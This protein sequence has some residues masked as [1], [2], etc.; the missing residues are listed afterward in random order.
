MNILVTGGTGF[1]G[2]HTIVSLLNEGHHV[3]AFD[4]F[5]NSKETVVEAIE[6]ITGKSFVFYRADMTQP[7][8]LEKIFSENQIDCVIHFAGYKAVGESV[9]RP[10]SYYHN[11]IYGTLCLLEKMK[12]HGV[13]RMIF[14]SSAT[15][16][17]KPESLPIREDFPLSV[18]NPYGRTKLMIEEILRDLW[19]SDQSWSVALLRYFNPVGA[20]ES[21]LLCEDPKGIPNNII[22]RILDVAFGKTEFITVYGDD[23]QTKD[24][25]GVRDYIH[26]VDLAYGHVRELDYVMGHSSVEAVNLGTG[27][28]YS[29]FELIHTF[30]TVNGIHIPYKICARRAGDIDACYAD[31]A[32]AKALFGWN[33]VRGLEEMCRD[34]YR[35]RK[36]LEEGSKA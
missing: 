14:S 15:V 7:E 36:K 11:N 18:T 6:H 35:A 28:G 13:K 30:E 1:I 26:V 9:E 24:G 25:T 12:Q 19:A 20:H 29:V 5:Y 34:A 10:L 8:L 32:K 22:P 31:P 2:S 3:I 16:Y 33:A 23:Y 27:R 4:N 17:G 21:G